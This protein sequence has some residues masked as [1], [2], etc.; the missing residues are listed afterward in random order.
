MK[1]FFICALI[2]VISAHTA[3]SDNEWKTHIE[4]IFIWDIALDNNY[5]WCATDSG[6][7]RYDMVNNSFLRY[8][9][10]DGLA[11]N[12]VSAV[13]VDHNGVKWFGIKH[14]LEHRGVSRFDGTEWT[15]YI[16]ETWRKFTDVYS[17][18][19]D[20]NNIKWFGTSAGIYSFDDHEWIQE[21]IH[22]DAPYNMALEPD[23]I[24]WIVGEESILSYDGKT[25]NINYYPEDPYIYLSVAIDQDNI[26][27][28]G[29]D[30][31]GVRRFDGTNWTDFHEIQYYNDNGY[32]RYEQIEYIFAAAVDQQNTK[33]F[34]TYMGLWSF[35]DHYWRLHEDDRTKYERVIYDIEIDDKGVIWT[36]G[37]DGL[38]SY[39]GGLVTKADRLSEPAELKLLPNHPNPFNLSTTIP[40]ILPSSGF[41]SLVIYNVMGQEVRELVK[42]TDIITMGTNSIIWNGNDNRGEPVSSGIYISRLRIGEYAAAGRMLLMK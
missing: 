8:T 37:E 14:R 12:R 32:V 2:A 36:G 3:I 33:W 25:W 40:F 42:N 41:A 6:V 17:V 34:G 21:S 10:E 31:S 7:V 5:V 19:V 23:G 26:K 13:A 20:T 30:E 18:F 39:H 16:H 24:L 4:N 38:F 35:D 1:T 9:T 11:G 28:F 27:W 15:T 22:G 29:T